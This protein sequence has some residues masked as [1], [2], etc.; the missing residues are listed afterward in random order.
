[1]HS[2]VSND[3]RPNIHVASTAYPLPAKPS[4]LTQ[5]FNRALGAAK[6]TVGV[7]FRTLKYCAMLPVNAAVSIIGINNIIGTPIAVLT[8]EEE[9]E[10]A[11]CLATERVN[12][13]HGGAILADYLPSIVPLL[14]NLITNDHPSRLLQEVISIVLKSGIANLGNAILEKN[15][16]R[17]KEQP[18]TIVEIGAYL[19]ENI[20]PELERAK[21]QI[22]SH[23]HADKKAAM[24]PVVKKILGM[25]FSK[26]RGELSFLK[27]ALIWSLIES[28]IANNLL[29]LAS[30]L[31]DFHCLTPIQSIQQSTILLETSVPDAKTRGQ[32]D[33]L[34]TAIS[35]PL[36]KWI[37]SKTFSSIT[38]LFPLLK[39]SESAFSGD[40]NPY[41]ESA[42]KALLMQTLVLSLQ[43]EGQSGISLQL[44]KKLG[45]LAQVHLT[46]HAKE[47]LAAS[48]IVN[49]KEREKAFIKAFKPLSTEIITLLRSRLVF[50][51]PI[52]ILDQLW[53]FFENELV[54]QLCAEFVTKP[55]A[56]MT[57]ASE[58]RSEIID[59]TQNTYISEACSLLADW[60]C[61]FLPPL[62]S[63][64]KVQFSS[65]VYDSIKENFP[66]LE[67][68]MRTNEVEIKSVFSSEIFSVFEK[69][70]PLIEEG[71]K[72]LKPYLESIF[73]KIFNEF[74]AGISVVDRPGEDYLVNLATKMLRVINV[75][76]SGL[77]EAAA[78]KKSFLDF[79]KPSRGVDRLSIDEIVQK[80]KL[81]KGITKES[82]EYRQA[83]KELSASLTKTRKTL[84]SLTHSSKIEKYKEQIVDAKKKL[85]Q[86][87]E[88]NPLEKTDRHELKIQWCTKEIAA[89]EM[90]K[91]RLE[92]K[93]NAA[94]KVL[95]SA[96]KK[97]IEKYKKELDRVNQLEKSINGVFF[98]DFVKELFS[99]RKEVNGKDFP[100]PPILHEQLWTLIEGTL[101]P[102][103]FSSIYDMILDP[104]TLKKM[105]INYS[106]ILNEMLDTLDAED[107]MEVQLKVAEENFISLKLLGS[108]DVKYF[109]PKNLIYINNAFASELRNA[110]EA[111]S[112]L[113]KVINSIKEWEK[114]TVNTQIQN[115]LGMATAYIRSIRDQL[116]EE[117]NTNSIEELQARFDR[118]KEIKDRGCL[119]ELQELLSKKIPKQILDDEENTLAGPSQGLLDDES[120]KLI[121]NLTRLLPG[122]V[123]KML[124]RI[125][126]VKD[127]TAESIGRGLR[128]QL[129]KKQTFI[130]I[131]ENGISV[132][133][134]SLFAKGVWTGEGKEM[135]FIREG[136]PNDMGPFE[137]N[138]VIEF[139]K[140]EESEL[141][142]SELKEKMLLITHRIFIDKF[143]KT[144]IRMF[145]KGIR[146]IRRLIWHIWNG[147]IDIL[148][149]GK[150]PQLRLWGAKMSRRFNE[151]YD[152]CSEEIKKKIN[153]WKD[154]PVYEGVV[155]LLSTLFKLVGKV[156]WFP[157]DFIHLKGQVDQLWNSIPIPI[158]QNLLF[159][160]SE[161]L[162]S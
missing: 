132:G 160:L 112:S 2:N 32:I 140:I 110:N 124:Y 4:K 54:P 159:D 72:L 135:K 161:T 148:F 114:L 12:A 67:E 150:A 11:A 83:A 105:M 155:W 118:L 31:D 152:A 153:E 121:M 88:L 45:S 93:A 53:I 33:Q 122:S 29:K 123:V 57:I 90:Q 20:S 69:G 111:I 80:L 146:A 106:G 1:M 6:W 119:N 116:P 97:R 128:R 84:E 96:C 25:C 58:N 38:D 41:L 126:K 39:Q 73:L 64:G 137:T 55:M 120:G 9:L 23:P 85:A 157:F 130:K 50:P 98:K 27:S 26:G 136:A 49:E 46:T 143:F 158:Q 125:N 60:I 51:F 102:T 99:L 145:R 75:H 65:L 100:L 30:T 42:A 22:A 21:V 5:V 147:L 62:L 103:V 68:F 16:E 70:S 13:L 44:L 35:G 15:P 92:K 71:N 156:L 138:E 101:L 14:A 3:S 7:P 52:A 117:G 82:L 18:I 115:S 104:E 139:R 144:P 66:F 133:M 81:H 79:F 40:R 95:V 113:E 78:Q 43:Q 107:E 19:L 89:L 87:Q 24:A 36:M 154:N 34:T 151:F 129:G 108:M 8:T 56:W 48:V 86:L 77:N 17:V 37:L 162:Q 74:T 47:F 59:R 149:R 131:I 10:E 94:N 141:R 63:D 127:M 61:A 91:T 142:L 76:F 28:Q 109:I 134:P